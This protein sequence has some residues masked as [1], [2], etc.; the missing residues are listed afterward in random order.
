MSTDISKA[1]TTFIMEAEELTGEMEQLLLDNEGKNSY[2]DIEWLHEVFRAI[3]T[4]KGSAG[5]FGLEELVSFTH[6]LESLLERLREQDLDNDVTIMAMMIE[7]T[8]VVKL[9]IDAIGSPYS[10]NLAAKTSELAKQILFYLPELDN[11]NGTFEDAKQAK[12]SSTDELSAVIPPQNGTWH[13]SYH[14]HRHVYQDGLDPVSFI[15]YLSTLGELQ[16]VHLIDEA[17]TSADSFD[18]ETCYLGFEIRLNASV[19]RQAILDVFEFTLNDA[20]LLIIPPDSEVSAYIELIHNLP[21]SKQRLGEILVQVGALSQDELNRGLSIQKQLGTSHPPA[22]LIGSLLVDKQQ[23]PSDIIKAAVNKQQPSIGVTKTLRVEA[24]KLDQLIDQ[25]GEMVITGA[26]TNLLAHETGNEMLIEA[27]AQLERLVENIRDSSLQLRMVQ[28]GDTFKKYKRVV[29][30]IASELN[31]EVDLVITGAETELDKT[32]V[33]KLSDPLTHLMRNAMDHGIESR[34][35]R[36]LAGKSPKGMI[37]LNA[38]HDS[39]SIVIEV[40]DDGKGINEG[41]ILST[42][43]AKGLIASGSELASRDV[44]RL[45]FEPGFSTK[46]TVSDLSGRGVGMDVV[47]RNIEQLRGTIELDSELGVGSRFIIRLPLTLSIIDGFMFQVAGANYVIPLDNV[48]EC[49][50]LK[51]ITTQE[52]IRNKQFVDLRNETLPF[53]RLCDWFG[54]ESTSSFHQ[55]A[56]VIVQ[57][58]SFRAGLV[59]DALSGE[60]QTVVKPLGPIFEGLKGVS[61]ATIL[62][63]GE[64]AIILDIFALIQIILSQSDAG[65]SERFT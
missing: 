12:E 53:M 42:A 60:Y 4:I 20:E 19:K 7:S 64:V 40:S 16:S 29:R 59:V 49:L 11:E 31:K 13:I 23:I 8:D 63:S 54:I 62:G 25:V 18:P 34:E 33:E 38:Y 21:E 6:L 65:I 14:P 48:V 51:E 30:D 41:H 5:L 32:F 3:H 15:R 10:D 55:E 50:E 36:V 27:M 37:R 28:I 57:F 35:E 43:K 46:K 2:T 58:G 44:Q 17:M 9:H 22:P 45:I 47:K 56:L 24:D 52:A 61:G 39:G 26:R 1:L